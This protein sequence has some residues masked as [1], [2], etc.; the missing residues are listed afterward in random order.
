MKRTLV[1]SAALAA[2]FWFLNG[3]VEAQCTQ[4]IR[5]TFRIGLRPHGGSGQ[6]RLTVLGETLSGFW[7]LIPANVQWNTVN[8]QGQPTWIWSTTSFDPME[9]D[10]QDPSNGTAFANGGHV[11]ALLPFSPP[12]GAF[13]YSIDVVLGAQQPQPVFVGFTS[14]GAVTDNFEANGALWMS[15]TGQGDWS[16]YANGTGMQVATGSG[17]AGQFGSGWVHLEMSYDP[18][19]SLVRGYAGDQPFGPTPVAITVPMAFA[20]FE[21][22]DD[23]FNSVNNFSVRTGTPV[24]VT[25]GAPASFCA[26]AT[27]VLTAATNAAAPIGVA[28]TYNGAV[29]T[30]GPYFP[31]STVSGATTTTLTI[32]DASPAIVGL[33]RCTVSN[34]CGM[35]PSNTL[36]ISVCRSDFNCDGA[37]N[38]QDFFDF[39]GAFFASEPSADF[40]HDA[41]VNSQDFFD[42]LTAFFDGC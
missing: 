17:V 36:G 9:V 25:V 21:A 18:A 15:L 27:I 28:W 19:T 37:V 3:T 7:P 13:T 38:S 31:G 10:P 1:L 42:F 6:P 39:L 11:A 12:A 26:G 22:H 14:S 32:T 34:D 4:L 23:F 41:A 5:D 24:T 40:N 8:V 29:I 2:P 16:V 35:T 20:G 33:Y 30:D